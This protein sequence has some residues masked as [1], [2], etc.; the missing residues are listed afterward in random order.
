MFWSE[1]LHSHLF[2][3]HIYIEEIEREFGTN[4][5]VSGFDLNYYIHI[6]FLFHMYIEEME[7]ICVQWPQPF[8]FLKRGNLHIHSHNDPERR[9]PLGSS[10]I[11]LG[12]CSCCKAMPLPSVAL[13]VYLRC[14][15]IFFAFLE[16]LRTMASSENVKETSSSIV[17]CLLYQQSFE[18]GSEYSGG[19]SGSSGISRYKCFNMKRAVSW[20]LQ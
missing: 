17:S 8:P 18:L 10:L 9:P 20:S 14:F 13:D 11:N 5:H 4:L 3:L 6:C 19:V 1:L 7:R 16:K 15:I 2:S 12:S